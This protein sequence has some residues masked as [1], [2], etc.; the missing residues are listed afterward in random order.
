MFRAMLDGCDQSCAMEA[1]SHGSQLRRLDRVRFD[2]LVFTNLTQD[3][4]DFHGTMEEYFEAKR[5]LFVEH[6]PPPRAAVNIEDPWGRKLANDL[7]DAL[8]FGFSEDADVR[9]EA[10]VG[11]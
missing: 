11:V 2:V 8:T 10:L 7:T 1:I 4:L 5:R 6:V 3:H 9:P